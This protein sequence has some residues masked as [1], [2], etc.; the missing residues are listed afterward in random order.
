MGIFSRFNDIVNANINTMLDKAE[1]PNKLVR[2]LIQ[3]MDE[4]LVELRSGA[5]RHIAQ[6]KELTR[7]HNTAMA[8][9]EEWQS[10]AELAINK[11]RDDLARS[12]LAQKHQAAEQAELLS[13]ELID[14]QQL[15]DN[16]N[17]DAACLEVKMSQARSR[18]Q[19]L[20]ARHCQATSRL[21]IKKQLDSHK[22]EDVLVRFESFEQKVTAI[23]SEVESFELGQ[24]QSVEAQFNQLA[25]DE[26]IEQELN[27]LKQQI[28]S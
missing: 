15:L 9:V 1:D 7:Q 14:Y 16:V 20:L 18:Q 6:H 24:G 4:S 22:I 27:R 8:K 10:R 11:G 21:K 28:A 2:L 5:A 25:R 12:A 26:S 23:E 17:E 19:S 13:A 3:E